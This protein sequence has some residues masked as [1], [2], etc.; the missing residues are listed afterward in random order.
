MRLCLLAA[1]LAALVLAGCEPLEEKEIDQGKV[2]RVMDDV[3]LK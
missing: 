2:D 3:G 1:L